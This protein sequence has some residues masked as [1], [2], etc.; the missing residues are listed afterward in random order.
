[1]NF[2]P[3]IITLFLVIPYLILGMCYLLQEEEEVTICLGLKLRKEGGRTVQIKGD[4]G[5]GIRRLK[6]KKKAMVSDMVSDIYALGRRIFDLPIEE[7]SLEHGGKII[8]SFQVGRTETYFSKYVDE[9]G[10]YPSTAKFYIVKEDRKEEEMLSESSDDQDMEITTQEI[11]QNEIDKDLVIHG[12]SCGKSVDVRFACDRHS[13]YGGSFTISCSGRHACYLSNCHLNNEPPKM[14]KSYQPLDNGFYVKTITIGDKN[15]DYTNTK[16]SFPL[17]IHGPDEINGYDQGSLVLGC[18]PNQQ[19]CKISWS[20][21]DTV[22]TAGIDYVLFYPK[23]PGTYKCCIEHGEESVSS[24]TI[25][26]MLEDKET[27]KEKDITHELKSEGEVYV[28][29]MSSSIFKAR[30]DQCL[31]SVSSFAITPHMIHSLATRPSLI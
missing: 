4:N 16:S 7:L 18:F 17:M 24:E 1:M 21:N 20:Q 19:R 31:T 26:I 28:K 5:G 12:M 27:L 23:T 25:T 29:E 22:I 6:I 15:L 11:A 8:T 3:C 14:A 13:K 10:L 30:R 2:E 9:M